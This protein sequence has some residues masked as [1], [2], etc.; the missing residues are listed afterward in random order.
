MIPYYV[1]W[2]HQ[3]TKGFLVFSGGGKEGGYKI[4]IL[5]KNELKSF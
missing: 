4:G 2:N 1:A 3:K 5:T